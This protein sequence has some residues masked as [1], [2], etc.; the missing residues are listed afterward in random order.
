MPEELSRPGPDPLD[1]LETK[2]KQRLLATQLDKLNHSERA[3]LVLFEIEGMSGSEIAELQQVPLNT[4]WARI[5]SARKKLKAQLSK[6]RP[7]K[8]SRSFS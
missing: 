1:N 6:A 5:H 2:E 8:S 3:A 7:S 4:V